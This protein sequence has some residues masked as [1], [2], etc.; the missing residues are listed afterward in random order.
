[1][2]I[3]TLLNTTTRQKFQLRTDADGKQL[4]IGSYIVLN[5]NRSASNF[6]LRG[7]FRIVDELNGRSTLRPVFQIPVNLHY[8]YNPLEPR[9]IVNSVRGGD[10]PYIQ[11]VRN[12]NNI[13]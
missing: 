4:P 10:V 2:T 9:F 13:D 1:M 12:R 11:L 5:I 6:H 8:P 3:I 7:F